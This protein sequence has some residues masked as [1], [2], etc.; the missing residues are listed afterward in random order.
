MQGR[1]G[2]DTAVLAQISAL[3][4]LEPKRNRDRIYELESGLPSFFRTMVDINT[5]HAATI[6][7]RL[8]IDSA[9]ARHIVESRDAGGAF[10]RPED[11]RSRG[12]LDA[13][14]FA[15]VE[16]RVVAH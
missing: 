8:G 14:D 9:E 11:L 4:Q 10:D 6:Q 16:T 15:R 3:R 7:L 13:D 12:I 2:M 1:G 5:D